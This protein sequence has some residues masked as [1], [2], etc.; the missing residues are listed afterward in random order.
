MAIA[1]FAFGNAMMFAFPEYLNTGSDADYW[2]KEFSP[3]FR[4]LLFAI[5]SCGFL[6]GIRLL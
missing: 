4:F 5:Y 1:G 6:F 3:F 2:L